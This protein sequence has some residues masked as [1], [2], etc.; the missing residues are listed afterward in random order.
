MANSNDNH[1]PHGGDSS[2]EEGDDDDDDYSLP[3][4]SNKYGKVIFISQHKKITLRIFVDN[5]PKKCRNLHIF[6]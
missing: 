6:E 5:P 4:T 1:C 2:S 3:D